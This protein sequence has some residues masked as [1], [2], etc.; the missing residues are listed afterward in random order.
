MRY[1]PPVLALAGGFFASVLAQGT[2]DDL[3]LIT[4]RRI[5]DLAQFPDPTWFAS[6]QTWLGAQKDDGTWSDVD[7][8]SGCP[9]RESLALAL[10]NMLPVTGGNHQ[11]WNRLITFA[12]AWSGANPAVP[13]KWTG[14]ATLL[15]AVSKGLDYW[16]DNDYT[17]ADCMGNG[18]IAGKGCPCGTPGLW[19]TN[20][21]D[22]AILIPQLCSTACLLVKSA[23]L[24]ESQ[25]AG[26]KRI[27]DRAYQLR[28]QSYGTGGFMTGANAV[29][30]MQNSVSLALFTD[31]A[32][33]LQDAFDRAMA[34]MTFA[35]TTK[36]DGIH[37]D[38]SFLQHTG[39][40]YN[41]NY[42]KDQ[43]N[44]F[45]QLE[46][47]AIGTAFA[48]KDATREAV[49][50]QIKGNEWMIF[51]DLKTRQEHWDFNVIGRFVAFPTPDLQANADINFN[52][53]KLAAATADFTG[54]SNV[55]DTIR[56]LESNGTEKLVGNKGFWASDYMVHR[57]PSF[58]LGNKLLS[59]RSTNSEAVNSANPLGFH[60]GQGTLFSY[61]QGDEY[62]DIMA[63]WDWN[64][65]PG[66]TVLLNWPKLSSSVVGFSG[67]KDFV[68][69]VSDGS[70][71]T[72]VMDYVDPHDATLS[73]RKAWFF[74]D[75][76]VLVTTSNV[77]VTQSGGSPPT[78]A[79]VVT[80]LDN[81]A[82]VAG[83]SVWV[84]GQ[85][86]L[87]ESGGSK[88]L[89]GSTLFYAGNGY[90]SYDKDF[91]LTISSQVRT[92]NWSAISTSTQGVTSVPIFSAY[93]TIPR[94][95][96]TYAFFPA[97]S[98]GRLSRELHTPTT[99]PVSADGITGV[100]GAGK[101]S[102]VFWPNA[103]A[104]NITVDLKKIGWAHS[105]SVTIA[106]D[107][108]GAYLFSQRCKRT[109]KGMR[110][111][112]TLSDPTQK[113][114]AASFS[115]EFDGAKLKA[116]R[117]GQDDGVSFSTSGNSAQ[118]DVSLPTGG[119]AGSSVSRDV[120]VLWK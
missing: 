5:V 55:N 72:A 54:T 48:A 8:T 27:P 66:T 97:S 80:V 41:G 108:P 30:V 25:R 71:G 74:F 114:S 118:F 95:A 10:P 52:T 110:L 63:A 29:L 64:L 84:D 42:G 112:I 3:S 4:Q 38:G 86:A 90:L 119:L 32:T 81:R 2:S 101:L 89:N 49:A 99:V 51:T 91:S 7:Y 36:Q 56:R 116:V 109:G 106:S 11:H 39:I 117:P 37:R 16:F 20:W 78:D 93:T 105:G 60:L 85:K 88:S 1:V 47:E 68:G 50:A 92:G 24:T 61:V 67:K 73:F 65:V 104:K 19:N 58:I 28:D 94:D 76:S 22:Q 83:E 59:T 53:S 44:A 34:V 113:L 120:F 15:E 18:G 23:N 9:A 43:L 40:L 14:D 62:K 98:R 57:R 103:A 102:V 21:Y 87:P 111:A 115:V 77:Q 75:D 45:I 12:A 82:A 100:A 46:G 6:I 69:V 96:Y 13:A 79:P 31:N 33:V 26:C 70:V 107:N 35:D 17:P